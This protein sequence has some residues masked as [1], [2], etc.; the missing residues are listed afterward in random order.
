MMKKYSITEETQLVT[1][2]DH[3]QAGLVYGHKD[4]NNRLNLNLIIKKDEKYELYLIENIKNN[5]NKFTIKELER[6]F[7][8]DIDNF[9]IPASY[10]KLNKRQY[11]HYYKKHL[12]H[13]IIL[14]E[15]QNLFEKQMFEYLVKA[16]YL[17]YTDKNVNLVKPGEIGITSNGK[18]YLYI[19]KYSNINFELK[20]YLNIDAETNENDLRNIIPNDI[21]NN[22]PNIIT[23]SFNSTQNIYLRLDLSK[24][25]IKPFNY[26]ADL[27]EL[28]LEDLENMILAITIKKQRLSFSKKI[29][30]TF[31]FLNIKDN[32][33]QNLDFYLIPNKLN[34]YNLESLKSLFPTQFRN[35]NSR[36]YVYIEDQQILQNGI[37]LKKINLELNGAL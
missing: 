31:D 18:V 3:T 15:N 14:Q 24:K 4:N 37:S 12:D 7:Y 29:S 26:E 34:D 11:D 22:I 13:K 28:T 32:P 30:T 35:L 21:Q 16:Y 6:K 27:S 19:G 33:I 20:D 10:F 5:N 25:N 1:I 23:D 8:E 36:R 2:D 17:K 9:S